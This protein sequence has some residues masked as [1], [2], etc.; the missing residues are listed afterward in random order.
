[1]SIRAGN[2][3]E[4]AEL[5]AERL[6][7]Q[8]RERIAGLRR[9]RRWWQRVLLTLVLFGPGILVMI[10][11]ND[12]GGVI[13]YAQTGAQY[14]LGFFLPF[15]VAVAPMAYIVQEM[16]VRLG[17]VSGRGHAELI[18]A[19]YGR[20]WGAFSLIDLVLANVLTLITEFIGITVGMA[21]F[22]V[23]PWLSAVGA[24]AVVVGALLGLRYYTWERLALFIASGNLVFVPLALS[25]HPRWPLVADAF[26]RWTL[27]TG[28]VSGFLFVILANLGTTIAP[29]M[30]FFQQSSVVDKGLT[31]D[32]VRHGQWDTALGTLAMTLV[33][34][35]VVTLAATVMP[36][37]A[38]LGVGIG[39]IMRAVADRV[40]HVGEVLFALGLVEAGLIAAI[41]LVAS[42]SWA[43][44]EALGWPNSINLRPGRAW[45]FYLPGM[46]SALVAGGV[47]LWPHINLGF[48]NLTVQVVATILMPAAL[49]FLLLLANDREIMGAHVNPR[50]QNVATVAIM[51]LLIGANLAF[52]AATLGLTL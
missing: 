52:G 48:V 2:A 7:R 43:T 12:A 47:V 17:A 50:W 9:E 29:W 14:G 6:R 42:T 13:T 25:V 35:A 1:V 32:D 40:G 46:L 45:R 8:D 20:F 33:A 28:M 22:G 5:E 44:G 51:A 11:D 38:A 39:T 26:A 36:R 41:A 49:L 24:V 3:L 10:A 4:A 34:V 31:P 16:T 15:L 23:P 18:W 30:L 27:P 37:H 19:R 21:V